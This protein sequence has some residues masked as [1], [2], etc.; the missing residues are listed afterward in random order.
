MR[1]RFVG[2]RRREGRARD[3]GENP[4][5]VALSLV[6]IV[7]VRR[8]D[9]LR[10]SLGLT[11]AWQLVFKRKQESTPVRIDSIIDVWSRKVVGWRLHEAQSDDFAAALRLW[12]SGV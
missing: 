9:M 8:P 2:P 1:G 5:G 4:T 10:T 6:S 3:R 7:C 11:G 12:M